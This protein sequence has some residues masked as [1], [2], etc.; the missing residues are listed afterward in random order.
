MMEMRSEKI[1]KFFI[2]YE[3][4][5]RGRLIKTVFLNYVSI[6]RFYFDNVNERKLAAIELVERKLCN[7]NIAGKIC[8]FH[9][10]T[11]Y[12]LLRTKKL[13]GLE[14]VLK[15]NRGLKEPYKYIGRIRSQVKKLLR[16]Y[17]DWTDQSIADQAAKDLD[18]EI[19]RSAVARIRTEKQDKKR[20]KN[21]PDKKELMHMSK[22][23]EAID[24][25]NF[26]ARQLRLNFEKDPELKTKSEEIEKDPPPKA[27]K[28]TDKYLIERLRE[29]ER[30]NFSGGLMHH[31]FLQEI[32][33]EDLLAPFP[34]NPGSTY[35]SYEILATLFH[36]ANFDIP[37]IEALKLINAS[38]LG[39]LIGK[40]RSPDKE[41]MRERLGQM[42]EYNLGDKL[43][44]SF[45]ERL[46]QQGQID[47]EVFFIDGHFLPYYGLKVIAK[48]YHTVRRLAMRGNELYAV[49]DLQ[50]RPLF[51]MTE[52]NEIDFRPIISLCAAKLVELG[53]SRPLLVFDRGGYGIHF[54]KELSET[55]DFVTWAK[56]VS[57]KSLGRIPE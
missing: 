3:R 4:D 7:Q 33:F 48:G 53:I 6:A 54:F 56:Y 17:P 29:G 40:S 2:Y 47:P 19:S 45:A 23:A 27:V 18:I 55:A 12:N 22:V 57:D 41:T 52:S 37:S 32:G 10:N 25:E 20:E 24:E 44:D 30:Y 43:I 46:L 26:D 34:L 1:S 38:E 13:L 28:E 21:I 9:R 5:I 15:D 14:T 8:G 42:A 51:F 11:V 31:L 36:S 50:G 16:T 35:G 49:T 39:V